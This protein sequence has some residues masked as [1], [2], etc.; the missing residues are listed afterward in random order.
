M[1]E[2]IYICDTCHFLFEKEKCNRC[3]DC[4]KYSVRLANE[5]EIQEY[6]DRQKSPENWN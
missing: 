6:R 4:G 2:R 1:N 3:P 5:L